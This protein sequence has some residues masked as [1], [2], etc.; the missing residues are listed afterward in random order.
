MSKRE[1]ISINDKEIVI[2]NRTPLMVNVSQYKEKLL[3]L[4]LRMAVPLV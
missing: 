3:L 2:K 4:L 1:C